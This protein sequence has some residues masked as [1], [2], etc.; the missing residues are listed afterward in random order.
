MR[1]AQMLLLLGQQYLQAM[2][3]MLLIFISNLGL[4]CVSSCLE[5]V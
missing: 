5:L 1:S 3:Q 4:F 2:S